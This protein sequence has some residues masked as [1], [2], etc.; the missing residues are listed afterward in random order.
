M[1]QQFRAYISRTSQ[2]S[3]P[4]AMTHVPGDLGA[5]IT[6]QQAGPAVLS[7]FDAGSRSQ[8]SSGTG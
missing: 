5:E 1:K 8:A 2:A 7:R 3:S 6:R 4:F